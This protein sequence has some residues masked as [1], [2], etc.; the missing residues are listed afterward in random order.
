VRRWLTYI[1]LLI[2]A[3]TVIGD[4]IAFLTYFLQ[5]DL[6]ARFVLKVLTVLIVAGSVFWYY[7][8]S[9]RRNSHDVEA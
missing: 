9:L 7:L 4:L 3:G 6:T 2:A 5:G 1:A 8:S